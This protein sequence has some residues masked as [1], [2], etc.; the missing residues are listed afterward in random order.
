MHILSAIPDHAI[1]DPIYVPERH[2]DTQAEGVCALIAIAQETTGEAP[3]HGGA[4][5]P[6]HRP[7][8]ILIGREG[9]HRRPP[10]PAGVGMLAPIEEAR[11]ANR[12]GEDARHR[13][14]AMLTPN[15][16]ANLR[17]IS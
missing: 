11:R 4:P 17:T 5:A 12:N 16:L 13:Y 6:P 2:T 10:V 1:S 15:A 3:V 8:R 9:K 7:R 14:S